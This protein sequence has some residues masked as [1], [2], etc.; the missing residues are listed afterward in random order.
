M[1]ELNDKGYI[2]YDPTFN[3]SK[4]AQYSYSTFQKSSLLKNKT[5]A[6]DFESKEEDKLDPLPSSAI[7]IPNKILSSNMS[8]QN[9]TPEILL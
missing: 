3:C 2:K 4:A 5:N 9:E 8:Q 6:K 1:R 7:S